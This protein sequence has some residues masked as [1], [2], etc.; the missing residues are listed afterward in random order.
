MRYTLSKEK[1]REAH[2]VDSDER[3]ES[4]LQ[5]EAQTASRIAAC[6][7]HQALEIEKSC[8]PRVIQGFWNE[9]VHEGE[10]VPDRRP[11]T[12]FFTEEEYNIGRLRDRIREEILGLGFTDSVIDVYMI[13]K[14]VLQAGSFA[15]RLRA[16]FSTKVEFVYIVRFDIRW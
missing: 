4:A 11:D 1:S 7:R 8:A 6:I 5:H 2:I 12:T 10:V 16:V 9:H 3:K 13:N 15:G 14:G